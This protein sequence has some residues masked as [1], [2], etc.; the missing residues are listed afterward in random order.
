[1]TFEASFTEV[2][3]AEGRYSNNPND[4]GGET[5]FGITFAVARAFGYAGAMR[6]MPLH[7][8]H[9]IYRRRY[10]DK[11]RLDDVDAI[12]GPRVAHEVF[13][14]QVNTGRGATWLQRALNALNQRG[15][16][17]PDVNVD[18]DVGQLTIAALREYCQRRRTEGVVVLLRALNSLQ[19]AFYI[20]L[21]EER[22]KDEDFVFG[23]LLN[24]VVIA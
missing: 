5:I 7:I 17:Y 9:D 24:R 1:M 3:G 19:G 20:G 21:A 13:D 6:D 10:W 4:S 14:S 11:C 16:F 22:Q 18:G 12:A 8:A 15:T 2:V 23:W